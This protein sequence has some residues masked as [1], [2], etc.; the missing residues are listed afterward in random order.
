MTHATESSSDGCAAC[1]S[2]CLLVCPK[3]QTPNCS[4]AWLWCLMCALACIFSC[5]LVSF[6][7]FSC[8]FV[9]SGIVCL[10]VCLS[11]WVQVREE[12]R[13]EPFDVSQHRFL[14]D[15]AHFNSEHR[16]LSAYRLDITEARRSISA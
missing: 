2:T 16:Q 7:V 9:S 1:L 14:H 8:L 15:R 3:H 11:V 12:H 4:N 10:S 5:L 13:E 6:R